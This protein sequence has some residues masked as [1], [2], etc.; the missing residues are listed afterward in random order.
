MTALVMPWRE[1]RMLCN[2]SAHMPLKRGH[3]GGVFKCGMCVST[4]FSWS[5]SEAYYIVWWSAISYVSI[6]CVGLYKLYRE[7]DVENSQLPRNVLINVGRKQY[8]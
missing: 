3:D 5:S 6:I 8:Y 2:A 1:P 4:I 7:K